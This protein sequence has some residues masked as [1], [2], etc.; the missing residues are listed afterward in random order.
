MIVRSGP[1]TN[2]KI[3][4]ENT[5]KKSKGCFICKSPQIIY[6]RMIEQDKNEVFIKSL[7]RIEICSNKSCFRYKSEDLLLPEW[8]KI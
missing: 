2:L 7:N 4:D 6:R 1:G 3:A 5:P 8:E